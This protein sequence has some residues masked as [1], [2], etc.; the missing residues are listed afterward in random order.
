M[1]AAAPVRWLLGIAAA[2]G[3][4][5]GTAVPSPFIDAG[6]SDAGVDAP[7]EA[8]ADAPP[9][10]DAADA[11]PDALGAPCLDDA[12]CDD[13]VE[14]TFDSCDPGELRCRAV[15]DSTRCADGV[16][17][18]GVERCVP[19]RGCEPGEPIACSDGDACTIDSC[20]EATQS[21]AHSPRDFD[22]DGDPS[23]TCGGGDC[24]DANPAVASTV[25]EIC[26]NDRDDDCD[27]E[28]DEAGCDVPA[29]DTC[30]EALE[31]TAPGTYTLGFGAAA[32]DY[33][34]SCLSG[35][36]DVVVAL[37]P[38]DDRDVDLVVTG[39]G[40]LALALAEPCGSPTAG[41]P[42]ASSFQS[43]KGGSV[44]RLRLRGLGAGFHGV[45]VLSS[46][47]TDATLR[48]DWIDPE[49]PPLHET[50]GTALPLAPGTELTV[51]LI[52]VSTDLTGECGSAVGELVYSFEV[53]AESDVRVWASSLDGYGQ[54]AISLRSTECTGPNGELTCAPSRGYVFW[55]GLAPGTYYVAAGASA[56]TLLGLRV[57]LS[58]P[59]A[60][61][62][63]E[64]CA[65]A[66]ELAP[67]AIVDVE[68]SDHVDDHALSC[69]AGAVDAAYALE[70]TA[71]SDVL[72]LERISTND[73][74]A[75][76]L[77]RPPCDG[78]GDRLACT[79]G[80]R[81]PV[82]AAA[83]AV[84]A[85]SYRAVAESLNGA[86][87]SLSA[88]VRPAA[89][90]VLVPFADSCDDVI[91]VPAGGAF[92]Q[93]NTANATAQYESGCDLGGQPPGGAPE[94]MLRLVVPERSRVVLDLQGSSY[95]TLL[96]VRRGPTCPG[97]EILGACA[98][99]YVQDRSFLDLVLDAGEYFVQVDGYS[100]ASGAWNLD[101]FFG[102]P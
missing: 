4:G 55:R 16:H 48:V 12:Q 85:G 7:A 88:L 93:G 3:V 27:G 24:Q 77:A 45:Y 26:V 100:G 70:L 81:S 75:V 82:R 44:A 57:D 19:A 11:R 87:I 34:A 47:A 64:A 89:A 37:D 73:W 9:P 79:N 95:A 6:Q 69:L 101:V 42:C 86:P 33:G 97:S 41:E 10:V 17:C 30:L 13:G 5:C 99:G 102:P 14:C 15:P 38:P 2:V 96:Q 20:V 46:S 62:A 80:S 67:G 21:C 50:C 28:V 63:D 52:G 18:N 78:E 92:L 51:P 94:Q 66:P 91:T 59:S 98:A 60:A 43:A 76:S 83:H 71:L 72:L 31:V 36:R 23:W 1:R 40:T 8:A 22:G 74:G 90:P 61:P 29:H 53:P 25:P 65:G 68:M 56:P 58:P 54:P 84:P 35:A 39:S 32:A 49:P